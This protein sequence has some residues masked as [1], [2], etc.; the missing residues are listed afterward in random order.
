MSVLIPGDELGTY[1]CDWCGRAVREDDLTATLDGSEVCPD[2]ISHYTADQDADD[3]PQT[4][5]ISNINEEERI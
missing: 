1:T 2:C 4:V 3:G 5:F